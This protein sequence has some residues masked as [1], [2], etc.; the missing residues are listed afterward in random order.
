M[1]LDGNTILIT[2]G[3]SGIGW[4]LAKELHK[5]GNTI[6]VTGRDQAKLDRA[7]EQLPGL[8]AIRSDVSRVEDIESLHAEVM[9]DFPALNVLINNAGVMRTVN[10][11]KEEG[12][13]EDFTSEIDIN[14]KGPVRMVRRFLPDLK[15][16]PHAAIV[17]VSSGLAFVPLPIAPI[18]C[19]TKAAMH[20]FS[21][22]LRVQLAKTTVKVF[23]IAPPA[24]QTELLGTFES[25]DMDGVSIMKVEEMVKVSLKGL[26]DDR[27]EIRPGQ[28]N[29]LK[30]MSRIAPGFILSQLSKPVARML[31]N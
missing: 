7:K 25:G 30:L 14:F 2:G 17:N 6:I 3:A 23:E 8:K 15:K 26:A 5:L 4:E 19:A 11:H 9:R 29:Q 27:F 16:R 1:K 22:S 20:S 28:S 31:A 13:L 18:Y 21:E 10:L 24:T 12:T